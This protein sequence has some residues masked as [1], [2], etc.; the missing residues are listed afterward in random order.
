MCNTVDIDQFFELQN[1]ECKEIIWE[2]SFG[3]VYNV[4]E[5]SSCKN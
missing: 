2:G 5:I 4:N 3:K 1:Y